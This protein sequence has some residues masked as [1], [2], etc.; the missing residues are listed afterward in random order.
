ARKPVL[1]PILP[2]LVARMSQS[3][4]LRER[5]SGPP[6]EAKPREFQILRR[7][8]QKRYGLRPVRI[9]APGAG[10]IDRVMRTVPALPAAKKGLTPRVSL[11]VRFRLP[12]V[13]VR[14]DGVRSRSAPHLVW[15]EMPHRVTA[16]DMTAGPR[17]LPAVT[18]PCS[19]PPPREF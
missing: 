18:P 7:L 16:L 2:G 17:A 19:A 14:Q 1:Q 10:A 15:P 12:V 6:R 4:V 8:P 11:G 5:L 9:A 3:E 13:P